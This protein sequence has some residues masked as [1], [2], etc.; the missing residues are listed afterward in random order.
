[1]ESKAFWVGLNLVK[2]IGAV[3]MRALIDYFGS[4]EI[5]WNSP[6]A[7]L[8]EAGLSEKIASRLI[9]VRK[10][11]D[12]EKYYDH[13][14]SR[15]INVLIL[16]DPLYP[17][18]LREIDQPPPVLYFVGDLLIE[19]EWAVAIVGTRRLTH[20]GK[21]I[22]EDFS[23]SLAQHHIS[24]V[25]GLAR[26]IDG[27]AHRAALL[28]GGRTIAVLGSGVDR[29][30]PPEHRQ[31]ANDI[32]QSG[33][34]ISDYP[35]GTPPEASNFPPRNRIISGLSKATIVIEAGKTSGALI[36]A[37]FAADQG[38]DVYAVPGNINAAQSIGTNRLIQ[39]G[40]KPITNIRE[41]LEDFR[42]DI[43]QEQKSLRKASP[44][45]GTEAALMEIL[46]DQPMHVD[47]IT[48]SLGKPVA[49]VTSQLTMLELKGLVKQ[50]G[51]MQY[52]SI[53]DKT[54]EYKT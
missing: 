7:A 32:I 27:V 22:T 34:I 47:E 36:T 37:N 4:A 5:A 45:S 20:Y 17:R 40:A 39:D 3:R 19:D 52:I 2:G 8:R 31:L 11:T 12:P 49:E 18:L 16:E 41:L 15:G 24:V 29:I 48:H 9:S 28:N 10:E 35:P 1:M 14:L 6:F 26:G 13:I 43:I 25:S 53:K 50:V 23:K 51:G 46:N 42:V 44:N 54:E 21:Q 30:Y 33:A 38:R